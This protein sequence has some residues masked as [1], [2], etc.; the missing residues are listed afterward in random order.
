MARWE[1]LRGPRAVGDD[2]V[3]SVVAITTA[4]TPSTPA[5][6]ATASYALRLNGLR[7]LAHLALTLGVGPPEL[8]CQQLR[9]SGR[10]VAD[11]ERARRARVC[12]AR[13]CRRACVPSRDAPR[14]PPRPGGTRDRERVALR[15][16]IGVH[17][18]VDR[19]GLAA[20]TDRRDDRRSRC[21]R[22]ESVASEQPEM[23]GGRFRKAAITEHANGGIDRVGGHA[24]VCRE[25]PA[26][27]GD[28]P[29]R[30][31]P[32]CVAP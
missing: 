22:I 28:H 1:S 11:A 3:T 8:W 17:E 19:R 16:G 24:P 4:S 25:L 30:P 15:A 2:V 7:V 5:T 13:G 32:H 21:R 27:H 23:A 10:R 29:A 18:R 20:V 14:T 26:G 9:D 31:H 6:S 12:G